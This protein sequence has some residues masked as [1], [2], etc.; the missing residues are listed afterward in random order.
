MYTTGWLFRRGVAQGVCV[1]VYR[2]WMAKTTVLNLRVSDEALAVLDWIAQRD[3]CSR[4]DV[5]RAAMAI[6][7]RALLSGRKVGNVL[8]KYAQ[9]AVWNDR[10]G[11]WENG[12]EVEPARSFRWH[13]AEG[14]PTCVRCGFASRLH[15]KVVPGDVPQAQE[16]FGSLPEGELEVDEQTGEIVGSS[17]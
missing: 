7:H 15:P 12:E 3:G 6:G 9:E 16:P 4:T 2:G 8:A 1:I 5:Q 14:E 17:A 11:I 10:L 13:L